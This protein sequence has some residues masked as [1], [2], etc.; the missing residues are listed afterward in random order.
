MLEQGQIIEEGTHAQLLA[1]NGKYAQMWHTQ[2][3][4][5]N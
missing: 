4:N 3:G 1:K 2:A 5:Y